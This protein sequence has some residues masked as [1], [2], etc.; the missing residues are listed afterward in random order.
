MVDNKYLTKL[1][2]IVPTKEEYK[3]IRSLENKKLNIKIIY[4]VFGFK[5]FI[6]DD[7]NNLLCKI[8]K[9]LFKFKDKYTI[10]SILDEEK[11]DITYREKRVKTGYDIYLYKGNNFSVLKNEVN[12]HIDYI[13][14]NIPLYFKGDIFGSNFDVLNKK[15][16]KVIAKVTYYSHGSKGMEYSI[17]YKEIDYQLEILLTVVCTKLMQIDLI[18]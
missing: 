4:T 5:F 13:T 17:E 8:K 1:K 18:D 2:I 12:E 14:T 9:K 7:K 15:T 10:Y 16:N 6:C 3:K 11:G